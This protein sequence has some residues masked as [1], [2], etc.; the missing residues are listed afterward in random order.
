MRHD[1]NTARYRSWTC[2]QCV[3]RKFRCRLS[4]VNMWKCYEQWLHNARAILKW[5]N[6]WH[7]MCVMMDTKTSWTAKKNMQC[8]HKTCVLSF[9]PVNTQQTS[10]MALYEH[11]V[12]F[13]W[14][15]NTGHK[16]NGLRWH[17]S[18]LSELNES[19][20]SAY[21]LWA[22]ISNEC[23]KYYERRRYIHN[24]CSWSKQSHTRYR[25]RPI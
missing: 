24:A 16:E 19:A 17:H 18:A 20:L 8:V 23:S 21:Q 25:K 6:E 7:W 4:V 15:A 14:G 1:D 10:T 11:C 12:H 22:T 3:F 2:L 9:F 5:T 13:W